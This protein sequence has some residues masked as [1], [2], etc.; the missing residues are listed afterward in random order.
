MLNAIRTTFPI[1]C[2]AFLA[3]AMVPKIS[4]GITVP[5]FDN[6]LP[7]SG[8]AAKVVRDISPNNGSNNLPL[9]KKSCQSNISEPSYLTQGRSIILSQVR[10]LCQR[11]LQPY[12]LLRRLYY[13]N[14]GCFDEIIN[15]RTGRILQRRRAPCNR[16]C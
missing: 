11:R 15:T 8:I 5:N 13:P 9:Y 3:A 4:L 7:S 6:Y 12:I 10:I 14:V 1:V 16:N 2:S